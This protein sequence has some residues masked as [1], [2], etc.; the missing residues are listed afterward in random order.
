[1][2]PRLCASSTT[3]ISAAAIHSPRSLTHSMWSAELLPSFVMFHLMSFAV[4]TKWR[5]SRQGSP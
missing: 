1:M 5:S 2:G 3:S 4:A